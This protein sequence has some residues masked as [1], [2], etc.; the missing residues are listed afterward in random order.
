MST[1]LTS[2]ISASRSITGEGWAAIAGAVGSA[3]LLAKKVLSPK[4]AKP[5]L[6]SRADFLA[7]MLDVRERLHANHLALLEKLD[8]N[9]R[10]LLAAMERQSA[11]TSALEAGF[12]RLDERTRA[13]A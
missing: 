2:P 12:A 11:R 4:H 3:F 8:G 9:H 10:E 7:E 5:E 1:N 13:A 6:M